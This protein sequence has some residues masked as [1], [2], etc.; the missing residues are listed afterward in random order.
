MASSMPEFA[1]YA[2]TIKRSLHLL[3]FIKQGGHKANFL[4]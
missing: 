2:L 1:L 4:H 3:P